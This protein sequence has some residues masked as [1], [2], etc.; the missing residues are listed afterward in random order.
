MKLYYHPD[1]VAAGYGFDTTRKSG[2]IAD[3]LA[4]DPIEGVEV[5][6]PTPLT[7]RDLTRVHDPEYVAAVQTGSPQWLAESQ[8]FA[9]DADARSSLLCA[10]WTFA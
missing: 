7:V 1:Y 9:W 3:S 8:G 6:A 2:W 10:G 4:S 5:T